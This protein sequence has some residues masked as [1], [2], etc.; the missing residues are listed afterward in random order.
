MEFRMYNY[1]K[2]NLLVASKIHPDYEKINEEVSQWTIQFKLQ[3]SDK[4]KYKR[5]IFVKLGCMCYP[6]GDYDRTILISKW[7]VHTFELDDFIEGNVNCSFF[8]SLINHGSENNDVI[9]IMDK[10]FE[11][12][13]TPLVSSFA[14]LWKQFKSISNKTWQKRFAHNYIW[15]LKSLSWERNIIETKRIPTL[16]EYMEYRHY[17]V[18][19][20]FCLNL[21]EISRNIF[22]PDSVL[23]NT[24]LQRLNYLT[25]NICA[26]VNDI[27]SFEKEKRDGQIF[28]LVIIMKHEYN[29]G[30]QEAINKATDLVNDEIKK[31]LVTQRLMPIFEANVNESVQKYVDSFKTWISGNHDW[32]FQSGR[33]KVMFDS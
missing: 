17:T 24:T 29:L 5:E 4:K 6:D 2:I 13:E 30:D 31:F 33:Y 20:D 9:T 27:Y 21:I 8:D 1:P 19:M 25:G 16:A 22:I 32:G 10:C 7:I 26:F 23:A 3:S 15:F 11:Y 28:N 18:G 14:D 12:E